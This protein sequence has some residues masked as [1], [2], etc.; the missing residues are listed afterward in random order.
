MHLL[1]WF[2]C[3]TTVFCVMHYFT[4]TSMLHRNKYLS[5]C[6]SNLI[7]LTTGNV[8]MSESTTSIHRTID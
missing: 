5:I 3:S 2:V 1:L 6:L 8:R 7:Y 4:S